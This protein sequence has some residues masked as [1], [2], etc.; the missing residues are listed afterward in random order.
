MP[1]DTNTL[2]TNWIHAHADEL[3]ASLAEL[4]RI[5]SVVGQE[6]E[7]QAWMAGRFAA[8]GLDLDVFQPDR[9]ALLRHPAFVD[10]GIPFDGRDNVI[11]TLKGGGGGT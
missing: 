1:P 6:A 2:V 9:A 3:V 11:G 8:L 4:V 7:A 5:P 10:S